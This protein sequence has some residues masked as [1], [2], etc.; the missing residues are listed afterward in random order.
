[1]SD[2]R[3]S[4]LEFSA[5]SISVAANTAAARDWFARHIG[6]G[7]VSSTFRKSSAGDVLESIQKAG[8]TVEQVAA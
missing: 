6:A 8:L 5:T 4:G 7:V 2:F 3:I 1:M